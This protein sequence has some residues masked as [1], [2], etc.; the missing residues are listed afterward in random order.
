MIPEFAD[1]LANKSSDPVA[2]SPAAIPA[3]GPERDYALDIGSCISR[4]WLLLKNNFWPLV[5]VTFLVTIAMGVL[6]QVLGLITGPVINQ[7]VLNHKVTA[8]GLMIVVLVSIASAPIYVV[9]MAGLFQYYLKLIRGEPAT[10]GDAFSGFGP[11]T[12]QL[13]LLGLVQ[14]VLV[15]IGCLLCIVPG[16]YLVTA[17]YFAV[18]LAIDRKLGFWEALETS[19]KRVNKHWFL[20]FAF[21][22]V[23]GLVSVSGILGCCVGIFVTLPIGLGAMLYA[24]ETAFSAAA[25]QNE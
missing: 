16:I 7:M 18:P 23:N 13:I 15:W 3:I 10:V 20:V 5:G 25:P 17:W 8:S 19:R 9:F 2:S 11:A 4:G 12:G 22:L 6:N 24:Y 1:V 21:L 14:N